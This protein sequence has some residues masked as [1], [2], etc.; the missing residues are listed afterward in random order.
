MQDAGGAIMYM[1]SV[2]T[3]A[4]C[5]HTCTSLMYVRT[6]IQQPDPDI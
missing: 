1:Y 6:L 3:L 2:G 4:D 5:M